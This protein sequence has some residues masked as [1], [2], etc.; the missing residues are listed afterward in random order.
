MINKKL[1]RIVVWIMLGT[2]LFSTFMY[3]ISAIIGY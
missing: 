3:A 1:M 2:M